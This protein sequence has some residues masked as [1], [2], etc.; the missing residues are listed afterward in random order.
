MP[1][2]PNPVAFKIGKKAAAAVSVAIRIVFP[3]FLHTHRPA[4]TS[5]AHLIVK[6]Q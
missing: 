1:L 5:L 4:Y 6:F 2:G 3:R